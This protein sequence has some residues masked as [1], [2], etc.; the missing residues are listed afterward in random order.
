MRTILVIVLILGLSFSGFF[1]LAVSSFAGLFFN[2]GLEQNFGAY[3]DTSQEINKQLK[4]R[5]ERESSRSL[6]VNDPAV[7]ERNPPEI[8]KPPVGNAPIDPSEYERYKV[9][10]GLFAALDRMIGN[11]DKHEPEAYTEKLAPLPYYSKPV[12]SKKVTTVYEDGTRVEKL[13]SKRMLMDVDTY[14]GRY[15]YT[16]RIDRREESLDNG[17]YRI[18]EQLVPDRIDYTPNNWPVVQELVKAGGF[19]A[20]EDWQSVLILAEML[21]GDDESVADLEG[22][23]TTGGYE[24]SMLAMEDLP[25]DLRFDGNLSWP[26]PQQFRRITSG[27]SMRVHPITG[28]YKLHTGIDIGVSHEADELGISPYDV[29]VM[30]VA[31][32]VVIAIGPK[33]GYGNT[34]MVQHDGSTVSLYAHMSNITVQV[35]ALVEAGSQLGF[36]GNTGYSTAP[37]LHLEIRRGG[38]PVNPMDFFLGRSWPN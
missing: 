12:V 18:T 19:T 21:M 24:G 16:Y 29:P 22:L 3:H 37:H 9:P 17:G 35:G 4:T 25:P 27:F 2:T 5:Y 30:A 14:E 32:G 34:V 38:K 6:D 8:D 1:L 28:V 26:L 7:S 10:W 13:E 15:S 33:G 31:R 36:V 11:G 20:N 23:F